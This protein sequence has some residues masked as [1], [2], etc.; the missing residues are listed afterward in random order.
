MKKFSEFVCKNKIIILIVSL[1]L[2][3]PSIYGMYKTR[4][5]YDI[6]I[7]LP[8]DIE[9]VKGQNILTSDFKMGSYS[10]IIAEGAS[11]KDI[12]KFEEKVRNIEGVNKVVS[13]IDVTGLS[14]PLEFLP[15]EMTKKLKNGDSTLILV[16]FDDTISSDRTLDAVSQIRED[17]SG[18]FHIGGMS[19]I[20]L[21]TMKVS[22]EEVVMYVI[23]AV[24]CCL[25]VLMISLDSYIA[26]FLL[27]VN[28]GLAI[29]YNMGTNIIFGEISYITKAISAVLQLGV[30][31]DF[32]IFLY[33]RYLSFKNKYKTKEEAMEN[34]ICDTIVSVVGS[35]LTTV[36]GFLALCTMMLTLGKDIGLV[37]AKGVIFG[38][39]SVVT[40]FP[41]ILLTFDNLIEKTSHKVILP[42]FEGLNKFI[43]KNYKIIFAIFLI[44]IIPAWYG[45]KNTEV[46][47][48]LDKTLPRDLE[49]SIANSKLK[50]TFNIVSP[51]II[52]VNKDLKS[53]DFEKMTNEISNIEGIDL[54]LSSSMI[55]S[56]GI[57]KEML[58]DE[59][60][61]I[62]END[63]YQLV[64]VNSV[65]ATATNE[66]NSQIDELN[67]IVK[68]YDE[69]A[70]IAG[71]GP[72]MKDMV[73]ISNQD[74]NNVNYSSIALVFIIMIIVLKSASLPVLLVCA[75]EFAIFINMGL[76]FYTN[77]TIP[78]VSSIVIG[79]IQL[80]ATI[81]YAILMTTKYLE[82]RKE[83]KDPKESIK[84]SLDNSVS[85]II[86]SGLCL[87]AATF[88]VGM[89]SRL[90]MISSI[91]NL[92]GRGALISM[93]VVI[94]VIPTLLLIFDKI[95]CKTTSG[96]GKEVNM[97]NKVKK[98]LAVFAIGVL[99]LGSTTVMASTKNETVYA[100]LSKDGKVNKILVNEHI[101][102]DEK[103][104]KDMSDLKNIMNISGDEDFTIDGNNITWNG[105]NI[106]YQGETD[107]SL[108]VEV[109]ITYKLNG[110]EISKDELKGKSGKVEI[111]LSFKN[112]DSHTVNVN[113]KSTTMYTPFVVT[114][115]TI[116]PVKGNDNF[117][118]TNGKVV[119]NGVNNI[120]LAL[121]TPNLD[122]SLGL[123][124]LSSMN[125]ITISY[126]TSSFKESTIYLVVTP[127]I[128]DKE[129]LKVFDNLDSL[130]SSISYL[131][132]SSTK[133]VNG[134]KTL[135]DGM[136]AYN[137]KIV[138]LA[139]NISTLKLGTNLLAQKYGIINS[140]IEE[141]GATF[142][143]VNSLLAKVASLNSE[144]TSLNTKFSN[145]TSQSGNLT[146]IVTGTQEML[147][148]HIKTLMQIANT[149]QDENTKNSILQEVASLQK[150]LQELNLASLTSQVTD[151]NNSVI[152]LNKE[153][154]ALTKKY[155]N[156]VSKLPAMSSKVEELVEGSDEFNSK[157]NELNQKVT[158]LDSVI[159][160][161]LVGKTEELA[162]GSKDLYTN[163][164]KFDVEGIQKMSYYIN[165]KVKGLTTKL[166]KLVEL[167]DNYET[168]TMKDKDTK[169][170]TKFIIVI[171]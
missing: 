157:I 6:L 113:G 13:A 96:F 130:Y 52:L 147:T 137:Q 35:S 9:T 124:E 170:E 125:N 65:Y 140:G 155:E 171:E 98:S 69:N 34:A 49:S 139:N 12:L 108:P 87:F 122:E 109:E 102:S 75:I 20:V 25:A 101:Y 144:I 82:K 70:I 167:G 143:D 77:V 80:G 110:E 111:T 42:K 74:F 158:Y 72:L 31:M 112:N 161:T 33:H 129:D 79:T 164:S 2:I 128:I 131:S 60:T 169:G 105:N 64:L 3:I 39:I 86:V 104:I 17:A 28:I 138:E 38:V 156:E 127:K 41:A 121:A 146:S 116:L 85:S 44:L 73:E 97:K 18:M 10:T 100:R 50:E 151:L 46:Y 5:N 14:L 120:A 63:N 107:K 1:L 134:S 160:G 16:T 114:M 53:G 141:L 126:E 145:I 76:S 166:E 58:G 19:S 21:D 36:A 153:V 168:F 93:V 4:V 115:G 8:D 43:V 148:N 132:S 154:T 99:T 84:Y 55:D 11:S 119:N 23:I 56:L 83:G 30:T 71:E 78:F 90:E 106:F 150:Q 149:T 68:K 54:V 123:S 94:F 67:T 159:S 88:G 26:P 37:M 163:L 165:G 162:N 136:N 29:L 81:D 89:Y 27:L 152:E 24:V 62:F 91:C 135:S 40:V 57:P 66:L 47:Y 103:T 32:S 61:S 142:N 118:I 92:I 59:V 22:D 51:E 133:L 117:T 7:Y 45:N 95:I 48:N 15:S